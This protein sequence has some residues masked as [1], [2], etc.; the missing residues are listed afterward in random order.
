[1]LLE[2]HSEL[3]FAF[4]HMGLRAALTATLV[5]IKALAVA[6]LIATFPTVETWSQWLNAVF[7]ATYALSFIAVY[8]VLTR[9]AA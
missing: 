9:S 7:L 8:G 1:N 3:T 4:G 2:F 6:L 5:L